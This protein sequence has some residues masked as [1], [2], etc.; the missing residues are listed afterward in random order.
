[1]H[2]TTNTGH[3]LRLP[4]SLDN[5]RPATLMQ[6][7]PMLLDGKELA[8]YRVEVTFLNEFYALGADGKKLTKNTI[9]VDPND[10]ALTLTT[11]MGVERLPTPSEL[12]GLAD[13]EQCA[14]VLINN[15]RE[16]SAATSW[17]ESTEFCGRSGT[18]VS[19]NSVFLKV[20]LLSQFCSRRRNGGSRDQGG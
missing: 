1:M 8:G 3:S 10:G 18:D 9:H 11:T 4:M 14:A 13:F 20:T 19:V 16:V 15:I 12:N 2:E 6:M 5:F 17:R 7:I